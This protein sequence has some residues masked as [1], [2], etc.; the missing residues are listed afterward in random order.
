MLKHAAPSS[1]RLL[2][3]PQWSG[4]SGVA[5]FLWRQD[6]SDNEFF[7]EWHRIHRRVGSHS[8]ANFV[9]AAGG[10]ATKGARTAKRGRSVWEDS[11]DRRWRRPVVLP[12]K[13][14][15]RIPVWSCETLHFVV[16]MAQTEKPKITT[17]YIGSKWRIKHPAKSWDITASE[18]WMGC[19]HTA[20][21]CDYGCALCR[22]FT[23]HADCQLK[24]ESRRKSKSGT[25]S[26]TS[27]FIFKKTPVG[28]LFIRGFI[29]YQ[30]YPIFILLIDL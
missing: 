23:R 28:W 14:R 22:D 15:A 2:T 9:K 1:R 24:S 18:K 27:W 13:G 10:T 7:A 20:K 29:D 21:L 4:K 19:P 8:D 12:S 30:K 17:T 26:Y 11:L 6:T 25:S 3:P 16:N 5:R